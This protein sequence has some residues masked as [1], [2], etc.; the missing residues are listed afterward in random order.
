MG[1]LEYKKKHKKEIHDNG[2]NFLKKLLYRSIITSLLLL[3][4]EGSVVPVIH[5]LLIYR[6]NI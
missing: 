3:R 5:S 6:K 2:V 4:W 1:K